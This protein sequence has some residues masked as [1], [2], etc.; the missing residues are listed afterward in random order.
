MS[1]SS[2]SFMSAAPAAAA[3]EAPDVPHNMPQSNNQEAH[4][5]SSS[6]QSPQAQ[7]QAPTSVPVAEEV[8][9]ADAAVS[10]VLPGFVTAS[11]VAV[12]SGDDLLYADEANNGGNNG[13]FHLPGD[14]SAATSSITGDAD[15]GKKGGRGR[16]RR[17][18][19]GVVL[20]GFI[21]AVA[22]AV[23]VA[24]SV[25]SEGTN[26]ADEAQQVPQQER[27]NADTTTTSSPFT[28]TDTTI[29][30][31]EETVEESERFTAL[32]NLLEGTI[33]ADYSN[34]NNR[35]IVSPLRDPT[36]YQYSALRWL[37]DVDDM[38]LLLPDEDENAT[39]SGTS[40]ATGSTTTKERMERI[41]QRYALAALYYGT[42]GDGWRIQ[43]NFLDGTA[44]ECQWNAPLSG[45]RTVGVGNCNDGSWVTHLSLAKNRLISLVSN[46]SGGIPEEVFELR[47][48]DT[49][50]LGGNDIM[51]S[52]SPRINQLAN[53]RGLNLADINL[54]GELPSMAGMKKLE[55]L[56]AC[57]NELTAMPTF[58]PRPPWLMYV[59]VTSNRITGTVPLEYSAFGALHTLLINGNFLQG[60]VDFLCDAKPTIFITADEDEVSCK[61]C[62]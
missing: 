12:I 43:S 62:A 15:E 1:A 9:V 40:S 47:H 31:S 38:G 29:P 61:C 33:Y 34:D 48:L 52:L 5:A 13:G 30:H 4:T 28:D 55:A 51:G 59:D 39:E 36:M 8:E 25:S 7:Q 44:H 18:L 11:S 32:R 22:V 21:V 46:G 16:R 54:S 2:A 53:L 24:L 35:T 14:G 27:P 26:T 50:H 20:A 57:C 37:A 17:M 6:A 60:S 42:S 56:H 23:A 41:V 3:A 58:G 10:V 49:L 19:V 45:T